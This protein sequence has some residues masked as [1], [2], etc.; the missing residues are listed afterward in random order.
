MSSMANTVIDKPV[1][2]DKK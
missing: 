2:H 1:G